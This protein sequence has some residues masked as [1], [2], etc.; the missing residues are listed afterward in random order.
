MG[1]DPS[2]TAP[3]AW[4][5]LPGHRDA[6]AWLHVVRYSAAA[7]L[8]RTVLYAGMWIGGS[9][10]MFF[11]T[12]FDPFM[13]GIPFLLGGMA[14]YRAWRGRFRVTGFRGACPRCETPIALK[15]G[16]RIASPHPLVC[17]HCHHEPAL[18]LA[19]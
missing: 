9:V 2:D 16:S 12:L 7:R 1:T 17:Y 3:T 10:A 11:I 6:P 19:A 5:V 14:T 13:T 4:V 8:Y 15:P 18:H